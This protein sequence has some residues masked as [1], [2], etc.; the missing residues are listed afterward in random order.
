MTDNNNQ[1]KTVQGAGNAK[2]NGGQYIPTYFGNRKFVIRYK[3]KTWMLVFGIIIAVAC[4]SN[5][6]EALYYYVSR[7]PSFDIS[8]VTSGVVG[9]ALGIAMIIY[10]SNYDR[11]YGRYAQII[12]TTMGKIPIQNIAA[13]YPVPYD[14][15][16]K[17]L[18]AMI[19][20]KILYGAFIDYREGMLVLNQKNP[21][22]EAPVGKP[23]TPEEARAKEEA[24]AKDRD[25]PFSKE[26]WVDLSRV[27]DGVQDQDVKLRVTRISST[28]E[29]V[30]QKGMNDR[31]LQKN[32]DVQQFVGFYV[33]KIVDLLGQYKKLE[34]VQDLES[35][36]RLK[37]SLVSTLDSLDTA[38]MNLWS[39]IVDSDVVNISSELDALKHKLVID[40]FGESDFDG[41]ESGAPDKAG[42]AKA[43]KPAA[44]DA[45][46]GGTDG[47]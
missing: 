42:A 10:A 16:L 27:A 36:D 19:D 6:F 44:E 3:K 31:K 37:K 39:G 34:S 35:K 21:N 11:K 28:L 20:K 41:A 29:S 47:N 38:S 25:N 22:V 30:R 5:M 26:N 14:T 40:G 24:A 1:N 9:I 13:A 2:V 17:D 18:Q 7:S 33:P 32:R 45:G 43:P 23:P 12:N 8:D 46:E 4:A 15:A